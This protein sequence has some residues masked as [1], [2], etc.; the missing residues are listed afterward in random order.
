MVVN[1]PRLIRRHSKEAALDSPIARVQHEKVG[2][3]IIGR[4][5]PVS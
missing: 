4:I 5:S 1:R 3:L 2:G